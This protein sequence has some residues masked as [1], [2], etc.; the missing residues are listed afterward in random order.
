MTAVLI[1]P[2]QLLH[3]IPADKWDRPW[4]QQPWQ[5]DGKTRSFFE[6]VYIDTP[7][8]RGERKKLT[9]PLT[10]DVQQYRININ[11]KKE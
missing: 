1:I 3:K 8:K 9:V 7:N 5:P 10:T 4:A 11:R 2:V 6:A